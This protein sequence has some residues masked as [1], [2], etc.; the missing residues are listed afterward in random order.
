MRAKTQSDAI[1][2]LFKYNASLIE[3]ESPSVVVALKKTSVILITL[4]KL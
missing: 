2:V 3:I 4:I 1:T